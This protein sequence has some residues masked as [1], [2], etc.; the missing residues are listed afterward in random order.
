M[1]EGQQL[2]FVEDSSGRPETQER[3]AG[4]PRTSLASLDP[5]SSAVLLVTPIQAREEARDS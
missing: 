1:A 3:A 5:T 2:G 4:L